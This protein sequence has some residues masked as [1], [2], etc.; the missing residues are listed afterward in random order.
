MKFELTRWQV[1]Y[2]GLSWLAAFVGLAWDIA[3]RCGAG[4]GGLGAQLLI[5][6]FTARR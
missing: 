6:F 2:I 4:L 3:P 5:V 1:W